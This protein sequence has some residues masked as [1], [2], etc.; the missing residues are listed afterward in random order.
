MCHVFCQILSVLTFVINNRGRHWGYERQI[1]RGKSI[2]DQIFLMVMES[3]LCPASPFV[4]Y[5]FMKNWT[6]QLW[7]LTL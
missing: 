1:M 3:A 4:R 7:K 5:N 6:F 2:M